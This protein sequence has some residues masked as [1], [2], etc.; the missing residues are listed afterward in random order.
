MKLAERYEKPRVALTAFGAY[1]MRNEDCYTMFKQLS[2]DPEDMF[3]S[4]K[5]FQRSRWLNQEKLGGSLGGALLSIMD[6]QIGW[7]DTPKSD[8]GRLVRLVV[9]S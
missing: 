1:G 3:E 6:D 7:S 4:W 5:F 8:P 2:S 9:I